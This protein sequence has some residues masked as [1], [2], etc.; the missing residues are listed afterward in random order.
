M[1]KVRVYVDGMNLYYGSLKSG[2]RARYKWLNLVDLARKILPPECDVAKILYFASRISKVLD[3]DAPDRQ[4]AYINA[5]KSLDEVEVH[6]GNFLPKTIWRP[7]VNLPV[8]NQQIAIEPPVTLPEGNHRIVGDRRIVIPVRAYTKRNRKQRRGRLNH[9]APVPSAVSVEVH[10]IEE[11]GSDVNLSAHLLNDAWYKWFDSAAVISNDTDLVTPIRM[12]KEE[13]GK[14]I[15]LICPRLV[16]AK[17]LREAATD[18]FFI[19]L[20]HLHEAQFPDV[21]K[22]NISKP[23]C[24]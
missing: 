1:T 13:R 23:E 19:S 14:P 12:V 20:E 8:A 3:Q 11:K 7:L 6:Y 22:N 5:L 2:S 4:K 18:V 24:W 15:Y 10:T 16:V 17:E 9:I 21:I